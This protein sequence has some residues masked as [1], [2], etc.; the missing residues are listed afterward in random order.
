MDA[1]LHR[2]QPRLFHAILVVV[3]LLCLVIGTLSVWRTLIQSE[4]QRQLAQLQ[5][6]VE[7]LA[8]QME[9]RFNYQAGTIQRMAQRW[10]DYRRNP[11]TWVRDADAVLQDFDNI[12]AI[13]WL[14]ASHRIR[15]IR[16]LEGNEPAVD[17][18]YPDDH[19]NL[20]YL[21]IARATDQPVLSNH[22]ELVQG[23]AG[24]A[25]Q[26]P[27]YR[28]A[29]GNPQFDGY[30]IAIFRAETLLRSLLAE[31]PTAHLSLSLEDQRGTLF[32][33]LRADTHYNLPPAQARVHLG[34]SDNFT[35]YSYPNA[36]TLHHSPIPTITLISGLLA[37][38][39][40]CHALWMALLAT[41]RLDA[42]QLTNRTLQSEIA[43]RQQVEQVLQSSQS[44]LQLV[45]D[46]T[47]YSYDALFILNLD[48][49]E[50][51]YMNRT[52]WASLDYSAEQLRN[53]LD[54]CPHDVMPGAQD[55]L[56]TLREQS[57]R[58]EGAIYQRHARTRTGKL[59]PL[60][61]SVRPMKRLGIDYLVCVGRNN[62]QQLEA[63]A[64]L[65]RLTQTD[66]LTGLFNRRSFDAALAAEWRRLQRQQLPLGMLMVDVDH[67]KLYND[68]YGHLAG[69]DALR[70]VSRALQQHVGRE[71]E[72]VCRYGGEEFAILLPGADI[73][74]CCKVAD[75][76]HAEVRQMGLPHVVEPERRLS[77]SI[78]IACALP[79]CEHPP[80]SLVQAADQALYEAKN[81]GRNRSA[82]AELVS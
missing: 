20:P 28:D 54:I 63:T 16:P 5:Q 45:L 74:Q 15:W 18:H 48:P 36:A 39:L 66:G 32:Q 43:R 41:R 47:D 4:T 31:L 8:L 38:V 22:F 78:G 34:G 27:L 51:V 68:T 52:C 1:L 77:V 81:S 56:A 40:L 64:K 59:V 24:L 21:Q 79:G 26:I 58:G 7:G 9:T 71:G 53:L 6:E 80:E 29:G 14:D 35:L 42:L 76:I 55:W 46:M 82:R 75:L 13:E 17:F 57:R 44:R 3:L 69:D 30:L 23:G 70:S 67:F 10:D 33:R 60:E 50:I 61:I 2:S 62:Y 37:S 11:A 49:F 65:E 12:Q 19:P 73:A 72:R 25:Y